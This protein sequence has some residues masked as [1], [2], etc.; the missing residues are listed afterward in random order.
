MLRVLGPRPEAAAT[1]VDILTRLEEPFTVVQSFVGAVCNADGWIVQ[2]IEILLIADPGT[3]VPHR[4]PSGQ[5]HIGL[6]VGLFDAIPTL[7]C[8]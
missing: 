6:H 7:G 8:G 5:A 2:P 3:V 4:D 1:A